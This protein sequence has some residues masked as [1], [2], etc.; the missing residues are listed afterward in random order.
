[1]NSYNFYKWFQE[2]V[3]CKF[4]K[5]LIFNNWHIYFCCLLCLVSKYY[6]PEVLVETRLSMYIKQWSQ[7]IRVL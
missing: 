2:I 4:G 7:G 5:Y 1:M 6:Y 3:S